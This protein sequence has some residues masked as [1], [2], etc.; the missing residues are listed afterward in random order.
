[1][2][3]NSAP[4]NWINSPNGWIIIIIGIIFGFWTGLMYIHLQ[5]QN[6]MDEI[7]KMTQSPLT[8]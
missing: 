8:L 1:M 4:N 7:N 6:T 5:Q 2:S 3:Y